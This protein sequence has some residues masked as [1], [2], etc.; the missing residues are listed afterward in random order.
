MRLRH[1]LAAILL[2]VPFV[3]CAREGG[4]KLAVS[5][6][7]FGFAGVAE[8]ITGG[9]VD[10]TFTNDGE[11]DHEFAMMST[12]PD[13]TVAEFTKAFAGVLEGGPFPSFSDK[14]VIP[15]EIPP[16]ETLRTR[17][18]LP[19]GDYMLFCALNDEP[20]EAE[21][22]EK[23]KPH[24]DLGM[25]QKVTV[26]GDEDPDDLTSPNGE[27]VAQDY[28][29]EVP[30]TVASGERTYAFRNGSP[31]QWHHMVIQSYDGS[32][33]ETDAL[34]AFGTALNLDPTKPPPPGLPESEQVASTGIMGP[35]HSQTTE[36]TFE[37][38]KTY[39]AACFIQDITGGPPHAMAHKMIK[40]FTVE[41]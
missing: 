35:G 15:G 41:E 23:S 1:L 4:E 7:D 5:A 30:D 21:G 24:Y 19:A 31:K 27:F 34:E 6:S 40:A 37:T 18:T 2:I 22:G 16:G 14:G 38:G 10:L 29:F 13:T 26:E 17:M 20:G 36:L 11:A 32:V 9:V 12:E 39:V 33:S 3:S 28:T 25:I 8:T